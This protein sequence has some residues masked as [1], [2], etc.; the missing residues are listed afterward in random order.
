MSNKTTF[1]V[2]GIAKLDISQVKQAAEQIKGSLQGVTLPGGID[3]NLASIFQRLND[4]IAEFEVNSKK[5][6]TSADWS[7]VIKSGEKILG[8]YSKMEGQIRQLGDISE[9]EMKT[10]FPPEVTDRIRKAEQAIK[11]YTKATSENAAAVK[12]QQGEI[13]KLEGQLNKK[14]GKKAQL[15]NQTV[16]SDAE[17]KNMQKQQKE[18][19]A[20]AVEAQQKLEALKQKQAELGATMNQPNK[21][22]KY[23]ALAQEVAQAEIAYQTAF[24][25]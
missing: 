8:L 14:Q 17:Y 2:Q 4:E 21:S 6:T 13:A 1:E 24:H 10:L 12:K 25:A 7:N 9:S 15:N 19:G 18:L 16:V 20:S 3:K 5:A 23:R 11:N 22:S